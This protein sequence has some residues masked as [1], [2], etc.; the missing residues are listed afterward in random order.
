VDS[1][2][3]K[4]SVVRHSKIGPPMTLWVIRGWTRLRPARH[5]RFAPFAMACVSPRG[6][7]IFVIGIT[8]WKHT[9]ALGLESPEGVTNTGELQDSL[10]A[11]M[12]SPKTRTRSR[13]GAKS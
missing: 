2:I 6:K 10:L 9:A 11:A 7:S 12:G 13:C 5:V 4:G 3:P 1:K 8:A